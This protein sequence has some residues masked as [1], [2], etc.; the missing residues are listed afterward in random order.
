MSR[1]KGFTLIELL[2]VIAIIAILAAILFPV[3]AKARDKARQVSCLSNQKQIGLATLQYTQ[4]Y[5]ERFP[6]AWWG[7]DGS[8]EQI[9]AFTNYGCLFAIGPYLKSAAVMRCPSIGSGANTYGVN[10][11][12]G[13]WPW[14]TTV[15]GLAWGAPGSDLGSPQPAKLGEV[16]S[17]ANIVLTYET[18]EPYQDF[19]DTGCWFYGTRF[20][21]VFP[22]GSPISLP[23]AP[24]YKWVPLH[25]DGQ[26]YTFCDGHAKWMPSKGHPGW[27]VQDITGGQID[28][29]MVIPPTDWYEW[30]TW[31]GKQ[32]SFHPEYVPGTA[33]PLGTP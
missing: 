7:I 12:P 4:D 10:C 13:M 28:P 8:E 6:M 9:K 30:G 31:Y 14:S 2:V 19:G 3:F 27:Y 15:W 16:V 20:G 25:S 32:I 29:S 5:D 1:K 23:G 18:C 21:A 24:W 26:T 17:P 11:T 22:D 33:S